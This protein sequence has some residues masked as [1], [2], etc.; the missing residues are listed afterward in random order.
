M[1]GMKTITLMTSALTG[2]FWI[3]MEMS[4]HFFVS[5]IMNMTANVVVVKSIVARVRMVRQPQRLRVG[6]R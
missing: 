1:R 4:D 6:I 5:P 3:V 2:K